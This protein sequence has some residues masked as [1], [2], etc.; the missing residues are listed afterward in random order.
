MPPGTHGGCQFPLV[1]I[2]KH[3]FAGSA[4]CNISLIYFLSL[5]TVL[6]RS[7][8]NIQQR[9]ISC[10]CFMRSNN[11]GNLFKC[12]N[13]VQIGT[14]QA[15]FLNL[16]SNSQE[17][18]NLWAHIDFQVSPNCYNIWLFN[19]ESIKRLEFSFVEIQIPP[20]TVTKKPRMISNTP[21]VSLLVETS[22]FDITVLK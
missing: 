10:P 3:H 17:S 4:S 2:E 16:A 21:E 13:Y 18:S 9:L 7:T 1:A 19:Q 11:T 6:Q 20:V 12:I 14:E 22:A 5:K 8:L 15:D